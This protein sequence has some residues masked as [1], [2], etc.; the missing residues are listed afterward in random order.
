VRQGGPYDGPLHIDGIG[1]RGGG[2][3]GLTH[4]PGRNG[5]DGQGRHWRRDLMADMAAIESWQPR[6]VVT[7]LEIRELDKL[8]VPGLVASM[9]SRS[10]SWHHV[11][12]PDMRPPDS[13][14]LREWLA[15]SRDLASALRNGERLLIHCAAGLGRTGTMV[16]RLLI[17]EFDF[18]PQAAIETVRAH[19]PGTIESHEQERFVAMPLER[20]LT[21]R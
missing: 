17:D 1:V 20:L 4:C 10:F 8:G 7:L 6:S 11:P 16:A 2:R 18:N 3:V 13:F 5:I 21:G 12:I 19:R 14:A 15:I 9:R